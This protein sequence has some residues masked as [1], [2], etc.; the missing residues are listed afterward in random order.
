MN[1]NQEFESKQ[2][3]PRAPHQTEKKKKINCCS[4]ELKT[5]NSYYNCSYLNYSFN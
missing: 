1:R 3:L 2:E 4:P 5:I